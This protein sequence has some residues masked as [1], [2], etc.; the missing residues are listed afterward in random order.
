[1]KAKSSTSKSS[2]KRP[3]GKKGG[4]KSEGSSRTTEPAPASGP[5]YGEYSLA[6]IPE[7]ARPDSTKKNA[8][9]HSYTLAFGG[10]VEA[11]L[12]KEAYFVKKIGPKGTG[13]AGQVSWA[14]NDGPV[15]AWEAAKAR[16]GLLRDCSA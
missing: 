5:K 11:L 13:P 7:E 6:G 16:A 4:L 12:Q 15:A 8:G 10:T 1:M 14:K 9:K 2:F 3:G